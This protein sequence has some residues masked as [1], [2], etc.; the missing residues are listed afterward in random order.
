MGEVSVFNLLVTLQD[1][2]M[3]SGDVLLQPGNVL[4][5]NAT[6]CKWLIVLPSLKLTYKLL[7]LAVKLNILDL[8]LLNTVLRGVQ[9]I[10]VLNYLSCNTL[11]L[12]EEHLLVNVPK[13]IYDVLGTA[14]LE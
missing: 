11:I 2:V 5:I 3:E 1:G 4:R 9:A 12:S 10:S 8:E 6:S 7:V 13:L 14:R